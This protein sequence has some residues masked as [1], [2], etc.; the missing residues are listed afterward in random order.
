MP[1]S[2]TADKKQQ[3]Q[4]QQ[5]QQSSVRYD[6]VQQLRREGDEFLGQRRRQSNHHSSKHAMHAMRAMQD[7]CGRRPSAPVQMQM[8]MSKAKERAVAMH[9]ACARRPSA[10]VP[11]QR[12]Q[13]QQQQGSA[14]ASRRPSRAGHSAGEPHCRLLRSMDFS[15]LMARAESGASSSSLASSSCS[16]DGGRGRARRSRECAAPSTDDADSEVDIL[17]PRRTASPSVASA[18]G[19]ATTRSGTATPLAGSPRIRRRHRRGHARAASTS[20][21]AT[22]QAEGAEN[23]PPNS[24]HLRRE[25]A[26]REAADA[27]PSLPFSSSSSSSSTRE[28]QED[29]VRSVLSKVNSI[30]SVMS[31][32]RRRKVLSKVRAVAETSPISVAGAE[33]ALPAV[34]SAQL[35]SR[36]ASM[37]MG[38][39][40]RQ[41]TGA[42]RDEEADAGGE[43]VGEPGKRRQ[44]QLQVPAPPSQPPMLRGTSKASKGSNYRLEACVTDSPMQ[45]AD[46][47]S[48]L[49]EEESTSA[50]TSGTTSSS[51]TASSARSSSVWM[52]GHDSAST[53]STR[54]T[55]S[56]LTVTSEEEDDPAYAV[57]NTGDFDFFSSDDEDEGDDEVEVGAQGQ[58][59]H[60]NDGHDAEGGVVVGTSA[61]ARAAA[62][63]D[64][65]Q[66]AQPRTS[67]KMM[68]RR[69]QKK[70]KDNG[71]KHK[72]MAMQ[73]K[74]A[75]IEEPQYADVRLASK[76]LAHDYDTDDDEDGAYAR[77]SRVLCDGLW[78]SGWMD[79]NAGSDT[80]DS[81]FEIHD[82]DYDPNAVYSKVI[83]KD[84]RKKTP[85]LPIRQYILKH[86]RF[87]GQGPEPSELN[88]PRRA[89]AR[90]AAYLY[91]LKRGDRRQNSPQRHIR[92][93][94]Q[95]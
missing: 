6:N 52:H 45:R 35:V 82:E 71:S 28:Q 95:A 63:R 74:T 14:S 38:D 36:M 85:P 9:D 43:Q 7:A 65:R 5:Q 61:L 83:P 76:A 88:D 18:R 27:T 72:E 40:G 4:Q 49:F 26:A 23:T 67:P 34:L 59:V 86:Y 48:L 44:Q 55:A 12:Q 3:Q 21:A 30:A 17:G 33:A 29:A 56:H 60:G 62:M 22:K 75:G 80:D 94:K 57:I 46:A 19:C 68:R 66:I 50:Y 77:I 37:R 64:S 93:N 39:D 20:G 70:G 47:L 54:S 42:R 53:R 73:E 16:I 24:P 10:P 51:S 25:P 2:T 11:L 13:Q 41:E 90:R 8:Q 15:A 81:E 1:R 87:A 31:P 92:G 78:E 89:Q 58:T 69:R 91:R 32:R 79:A 84:R